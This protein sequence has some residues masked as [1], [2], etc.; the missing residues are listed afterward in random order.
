MVNSRGYTAAADLQRQKTNSMV[1]ESSIK[2]HKLENESLPFA[3]KIT[4]EISAD[5]KK[6]IEQ[7]L[8]LKGVSFDEVK[9]SFYEL[10]KKKI[11][12]YIKGQMNDFDRYFSSDSKFLEGMVFTYDTLKSKKEGIFSGSYVLLDIDSGGGNEVKPPA[13]PCST[14]PSADGRIR[15]PAQGDGTI[16]KPYLISTIGE[17]QSM[18]LSPGSFFKLKNDIEACVTKD[19]N[20]KEGFEPLPNFTGSLDNGGFSVNNLY[21]NRPLENNIGVVRQ[22][23]ITPGRFFSVRLKTPKIIGNNNVGIVGTLSDGKLD[24]VR[25]ENG[26]VEGKQNVGGIAG[27]NDTLASIFQSNFNG[28]VIGDINVGGLA[29]KT[30]RLDITESFIRG[31]VNG[32][33]FVGGLVGNRTDKF[34]TIKNVYIDVNIQGTSN[35]RILN[36]TSSGTDFITNVFYNKDKTAGIT[37]DAG[38]GKTT[39]ELQTKATFTGFDFTKK[40]II[41]PLKNDGFPYLK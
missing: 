39:V 23:K 37:T 19:W 32:T 2:Q 9:D 35:T 1:L 30:D 31:K 25:V 36:G 5:T 11:K 40:W 3:S 12:M 17:F 21:I 10:D 22:L 6:I 15:L 33:S 28:E 27:F 16:T 8:K 4:K 38:T 13:G 41:D 7:Q 29:G 18:K 20:N 26:Y 24:G 14:D 34:G